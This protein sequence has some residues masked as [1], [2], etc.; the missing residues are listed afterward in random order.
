MRIAHWVM[1]NGS[2][3]H[4][5]AEDMCAGECALGHDSI[6][7]NTEDSK[8]W[9]NGVGY[10]V[11]VV[12]TH[13]PDIAYAQNNKKI[14]FIPHGTPEHVFQGAMDKGLAGGY[15]M[16]DSWMVSQHWVNKA[17]AVI[18]FWDRH[19][20]IWQQLNSKTRIYVVPIGIDTEFWKPTPSL[21]RWLGSPAILTA[22]NCHSIK[23]PLDLF[24]ALP[25][26][27]K[28][29]VGLRLH[30]W[31]VPRDQHRWWFPLVNNN[32]VSFRSYI[33]E[34]RMDKTTLRN[35]FNSVDY[36][37]GL[38][39]YGDYNRICLEAKASGCKVISYAGN[40]YADFWVTEGDQR[41]MAEELL[42]ILKG[43]VSALPC[44]APSDRKDVAKEMIKIYEE[45]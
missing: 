10:E 30:A 27:M 4:N 8:E 44:L 31:Y 20:Y 1:K 29:I 42:K 9:E 18:T 21:G 41:K 34:N 16:S 32:G 37:V 12:H 19:K 11:Y 35:A 14:I 6:I 5:V 2:G 15:G 23:Y 36:Y 33:T 25:E 28:E 3:M 40:P 7:I 26:V 13:L 43:E 22:E 45:A 38:V 24:L 17:D 39:R